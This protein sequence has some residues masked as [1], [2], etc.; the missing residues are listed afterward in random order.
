MRIKLNWNELLFLLLM[1]GG[2]W[3]L[4]TPT[5]SPIADAQLAIS[6]LTQTGRL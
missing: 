3:L 5:Y 1:L 4:L 2:L 6:W